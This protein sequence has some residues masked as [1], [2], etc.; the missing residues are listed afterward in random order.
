MTHKQYD[1]SYTQDRELSWL[2]F[3]H[4][5]L[6]EAMDPQTPLMERMKFM[7]IFTSNLDEFFMIRVGSLYDLSL[8]PN[9]HKD[10]KT[11]WTPRQQL[12]HIFEAV[13][14]LY[15]ER[16]DVFHRLE[17]E[18]AAREVIH[19]PFNALTEK[20]KKYVHHY[21]QSVVMPVLSPQVVDVHH[22]FP[23]LINKAQYFLLRLKEEHKE[24]FGILPLPTLLPRIVKLPGHEIRY[25]LLEEIIAPY[26]EKLLEM[27]KVEEQV[28]VCVT[29]NADIS[30]EDEGV[31]VEDDFRR[32]M[33]KAL[34]KRARMHPVRLEVQGK[35]SRDM[36]NFLC[37][38]LDIKHEQVFISKAPMDLSYV[39]ALSDVFPQM[40]KELFYPKFT[41]KYPGDLD[42][43]ES[44]IRQIQKRDV[45][46]FYPYQ[47][48]EPF[49]QLVK[50]ASED[51]HVLSIK[52]T[53]YR[54]AKQSRLVE[55]LVAA[56]ERGKEVTVLMELKARFDEQN[57]INYA[58]I[59]EDAGCTLLY[60]FD[61]YKVHS[62]ILLITRHVKNKVQYITQVGTGNYNEKTAKLYTDFSLM[63]ADNAIGEDAD[64]F[65]KNMAVAN[66]H[67]AY[68][69]LLVAPHALKPAL[70]HCIDHEIIK[71]QN[72][73]EGY[74]AMKMNSLTDRALIDKLAEAS[75][76][77]V[78]IQLLIRGICCLVPGIEGKTENITVHSIVGRFLEHARVYCFGTEED[79]KLYISSADLMTRNMEKRVEI[80]CPVMDSRLQKR[81]CLLMDYMLR[82]NV[83]ARELHND[84]NYHEVEQGELP[85]IDS[86]ATFMERAKQ[87]EKKPPLNRALKRWKFWKK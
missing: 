76:A 26:I 51:P 39:Y 37:T 3:N 65:F 2:K 87:N 85:P 77:G 11:G 53:I 84:Q 41:P 15:E 4:R 32:Q 19:V 54:L 63:T 7:A 25:I 5:V 29:R 68:Q 34:K 36:R 60:G 27:Y 21:V 78:K 30:P 12:Q 56:A 47:S 1:Y 18:L 42:H 14:P 16:D 28:L 48:M 23:H 33:K 13:R 45:L 86:Q 22:P 31:D 80:A 35:L 59:L 9:E 64:A 46:L 8:L 73:R 24:Q 72:G 69:H 49:L 79:R 74:I 52:I 83:K 38:K 17:A 61:K 67:G 82:D 58:E 6:Q 10:N 66:L 20:E 70:L 71:Q 40:E 43:D 50:Q 57:N 44:M 62:K 55:Y 75:Q 81:I